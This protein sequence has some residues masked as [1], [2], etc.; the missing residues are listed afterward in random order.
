MGRIPKYRTPDRFTAGS[1]KLP[2]KDAPLPEY[3]PEV[4][5]ACDPTRVNETHAYTFALVTGANPSYG[6]HFVVGLRKGAVDFLASRPPPSRPHYVLAR[7]R[8]GAAAKDRR[9]AA[10]PNEYV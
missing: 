10:P 8:I 2:K 3:Q 9:C 1:R 4:T 7:M 5:L 6:R